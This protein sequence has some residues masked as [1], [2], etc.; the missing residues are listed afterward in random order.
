APVLVN[1]YTFGI[2]PAAGSHYD[3]VFRAGGWI[4]VPLHSFWDQYFNAYYVSFSL[5]GLFLIGQWG[6]ATREPDKKKQS[7]LLIL[8][9]AAAVVLGTLTDVI[10]NSFL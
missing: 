7:Q 10:A 2:S 9:F 1:V 8:A 6:Y 4:N 5:V 3:L